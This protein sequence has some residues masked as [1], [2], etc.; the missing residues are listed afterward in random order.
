MISFVLGLWIAGIATVTY[1]TSLSQ[2][3]VS[4]VMAIPPHEASKW[5]DVLGADRMRIML[6]HGSA[7]LNRGLLEFWGNADFVICLFL[8]VAV[9]MNKSGKVLIILTAVLFLLGAAAGFLLTPQM[10]AVGRQLDFRVVFPVPPAVA[11]FAAL[12][13]MYY[14]LAVTRTLIVGTMVALLLHRS[15]RSPRVRRSRLDEVDTVNDADHRGI[16]R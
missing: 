9:V 14:G 2:R 16:Y 10:V 13:R 6:L 4:S 11:Q 8:F 12:E 5:I 15:G 7:G 3:T 1:I